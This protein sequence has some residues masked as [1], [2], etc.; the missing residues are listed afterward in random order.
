MIGFI[1]FKNLVRDCPIGMV[2]FFLWGRLPVIILWYLLFLHI[3]CNF[4]LPQWVIQKIDAT[5]ASFLWKGPSPMKKGSCPAKKGCHL[6]RG[7]VCAY[8]NNKVVYGSKFAF[9]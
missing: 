4:N 1:L 2:S 8:L 5:R 7:V 3:S 9:V 6:A